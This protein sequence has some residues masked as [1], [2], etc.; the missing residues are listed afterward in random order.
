MP[1]AVDLRGAVKPVG[2]TGV[3]AGQLRQLV[4]E[5]GAGLERVRAGAVDSVEHPG[6]PEL[7]HRDLARGPVALL[8]AASV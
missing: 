5:A 4:R 2:R 8:D 7:G 3:V 6:R 1:I